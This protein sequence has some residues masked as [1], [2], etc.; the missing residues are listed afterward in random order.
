MTSFR[1]ITSMRKQKLTNKLIKGNKTCSMMPIWNY[2]VITL[3][4]L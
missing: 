4:V 2:S 1:K 3:D